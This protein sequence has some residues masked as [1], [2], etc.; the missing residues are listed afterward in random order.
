MIFFLK[1]KNV[2]DPHDVASLPYTKVFLFIK[3]PIQ[4]PT[5]VGTLG[6]RLAIQK[7]RKEKR[8]KKKTP[9]PSA[10]LIATSPFT[11]PFPFPP[12]I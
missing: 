9:S 4:L 3:N 8:K 2:C 11:P 10:H 12:L 1:K 6:R 5:K 7:K